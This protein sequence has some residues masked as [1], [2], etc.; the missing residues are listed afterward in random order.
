MVWFERQRKTRNTTQ[1]RSDPFLIQS[2][3]PGIEFRDADTQRALATD[4]GLK[5]SKKQ[6]LNEKSSLASQKGAFLLGMEHILRIGATAL[7]RMAGDIGAAISN[8]FCDLGATVSFSCHS[9]SVSE[10]A[11][12]RYARDFIRSVIELLEETGESIAE[13][14]TSGTSST[15]RAGLVF[16]AVGLGTTESKERHFRWFQL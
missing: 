9:I 12:L 16:A 7:E 3:R 6:L 2:E 1:L 11:T 4:C 5:K 14:L 13:P 10:T 8:R 15:A